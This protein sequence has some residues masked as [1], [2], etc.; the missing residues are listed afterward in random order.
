[1]D[2]DRQTVRIFLFL[3]EIVLWSSFGATFAA[4]QATQP[5]PAPSSQTAAKRAQTPV[6]AE[7]VFK[8]VQVLKGIPV[9][10]FMDTMGFFAA[11]LSL[12]CTSCHGLESASDVSK[13]AD[14][15]PLKQTARKMILMVRAINR[16]HFAGQ[17][18]ITCY[19]CHRG[20]ERPK[21]RPSLAEQYGAPPPDD[22]NEVEI[23]GQASRGPSA[24]QIFDKY[25]AA[26][27]NPQQLAQITSFVAKGTYS[28]YDTD[29][30]K[31]PVEV[32]A[33]APDKHAMMV[34]MP[35]GD[36]TVSYDG[37]AGWLA[38]PATPVPLMALTGQDLDGAKVEAELFFPAKIKQARSK[39][40][41]G[42]TTIDDLD[43]EVVEGTGTG[44]IP[45]KLYFDTKSGLL[46]RSVRFTNT[47]VGQVTTQVDYSDYRDVSGV[48]MPF[49]WT[50]T[51]VDG[52]STTELS[53]IEANARIDAAK[54]GK[55][56]PAA[57]P[58]ER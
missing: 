15:T 27:G 43:V 40:Q 58:P 26:L 2:R 31:Y 25:L 29:K 23:S 1:M 51:W 21:E 17:R 16:E 52:Q 18:L 19:T 53:G 24:D 57:K 50:E 44:Q 48:K 5:K 28:G 42:A 47:V 54:F 32:F 3:I 55:P 39:W 8:N 20:D 45:I 41:V 7:D 12:N 4:G 49:K 6:L 46:V 13:F 38:E 36:K 22:P 33:Q 56:A 37:R 14:D 35:D 10:E 30:E 9:S 34:H 11:S